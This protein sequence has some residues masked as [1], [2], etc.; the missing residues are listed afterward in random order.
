MA[1]DKTHPTLT[2]SL[3]AIRHLHLW[4]TT[5]DTRLTLIAEA[6]RGLDHDQ[7]RALNNDYPRL[8]DALLQIEHAYR[9]GEG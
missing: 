1:N 2:A 7:R 6:V 9:E 5:A 3:T 4:A 8:M